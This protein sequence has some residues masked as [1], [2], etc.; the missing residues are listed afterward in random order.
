M[1]CKSE[2]SLIA[3]CE[4][5]GD[6]QAVI[7]TRRMGMRFRL[8]GGLLIIDSFPGRCNLKFPISQSRSIPKGL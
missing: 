8:R 4:A 2:C 3:R 6:R 1:L 7:T 5:M